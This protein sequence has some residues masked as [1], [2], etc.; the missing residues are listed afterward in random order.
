MSFIQLLYFDKACA[1]Y[2]KNNPSPIVLSLDRTRRQ[3]HIRAGNGVHAAYLKHRA[4]EEGALKTLSFHLNPL[5]RALLR[6]EKEAF[7][8]PYLKILF[9]NSH[10]VRREITAHYDISPDKIAVVHNGVE[11]HAM[12]TPFDTWQEGK[13]IAL[14][15]YGL[16]PSCFQFLFIGHNYRRKGLDKL[17]CALSTLKGVRFNSA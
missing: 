4:K 11:W 12:Q 9:T 2:L 15:K 8:D 7:E 5:H 16:D 10:M 6:I 3:T 1:H 17:L 13:S 14:K